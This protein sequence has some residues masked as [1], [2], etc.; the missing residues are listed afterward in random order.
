MMGKLRKI[1]TI[2]FQRFL[3][4]KYSNFT[5][6]MPDPIF[7][8]LSRIQFKILCRIHFYGFY[9][10]SKFTDFMPYL[11]LQILCQILFYRFYAGSNLTD[12]MPDSHELP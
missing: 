11:I 10:G 5:T 8:I 7:V 4:K 12:F 6:F 3:I 9:A 2:L 1:K